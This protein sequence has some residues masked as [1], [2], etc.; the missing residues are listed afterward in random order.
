MFPDTYLQQKNKN[1]LPEHIPNPGGDGLLG[2]K[3]M[4]DKDFNPNHNSL[5]LKIGSKKKKKDTC[6]SWRMRTLM[7]NIMFYISTAGVPGYGK[8]TRSALIDG[9]RQSL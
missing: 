7:C 6:S 3:Q 1:R 2:V 5:L 9:V 4:G 8:C